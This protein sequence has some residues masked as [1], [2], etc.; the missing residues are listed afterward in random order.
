[1]AFRVSLSNYDT[2]NF[3]LFLFRCQSF[4]SF[5]AKIFVSSSFA[6]LPNQDIFSSF[7]SLQL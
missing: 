6:H 4:F 2:N 1:M 7:F 3:C 5:C